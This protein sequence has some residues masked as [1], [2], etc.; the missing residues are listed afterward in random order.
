MILDRQKEILHRARH[1]LV[2]AF[3]MV[4]AEIPVGE[5]F[6]EKNVGVAVKDRKAVLKATPDGMIMQSALVLETDEECDA[7]VE[8]ST[9]F[10]GEISERI[11]NRDRDMLKPEMSSE[12]RD[13]L[14]ESE[15]VIYEASGIAKR[16]SMEF[17][18]A[19][20]S[21]ASS[22]ISFPFRKLAYHFSL[23]NDK[24]A[25]YNGRICSIDVTHKSAISAR[26]FYK[27]PSKTYSTGYSLRDGERILNRGYNALVAAGMPL[28]R[29]SDR[30]FH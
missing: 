6:N 13:A 8:R 19:T 12:D 28:V 18:D 25:A 29:P 4:E 23:I 1:R 2:L 26:D 27:I 10:L 11:R 9:I 17:T 5:A 3:L 16:I 14:F 15:D 20:T 30:K 7:L 22:M 21:F 24:L